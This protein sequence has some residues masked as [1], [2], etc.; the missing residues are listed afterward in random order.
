MFGSQ[1]RFVAR[2]GNRGIIDQRKLGIPRLG[3]RVEHR[4]L[5]MKQQQQKNNQRPKPEHKQVNEDG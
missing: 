3:L 4:E 2:L 1:A 5:N